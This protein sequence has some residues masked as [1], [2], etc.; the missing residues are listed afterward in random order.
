MKVLFCTDGSQ[1]SYD[2]IT[3]FS[4]WFKNFKTDILS[5]ADWSCLSDTIITEG[6]NIMSYCTNNANAIIN[7]ARL[8]LEERNIYVRNTDKNCGS[9]T[10]SILEAE[11]KERYD[12]LVLGSNGKKGIQRWL[13]SVSQDIS[14]LSQTSVY[15]S[16]RKTQQNKIAFALEESLIN[17]GILENT[18]EYM[19]LEDKEIHLL[20]VYETPD[21]MFLDGAIDSNWI[22][23]ITAK[24][25]KEADKTLYK[26]E[27]IFKDYGFSPNVK[28]I[29]SGN[30]SKEIIEYCSKNEI[31]LIVSGMRKRKLLSRMFPN[32]V[33]K[34]ILENTESDILIMK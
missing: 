12:F 8:Y 23:D 16:K 24:Q 5:V 4:K 7:N 29:L 1:I 14:M 17:R 15:I 11:N 31:D 26:F 34:R 22:N 25:E 3:N 6:S 33:S 18:L 28:S 2:S 32:S 20:T 13:G 27:G 19:N 21:Y 10:D 9:V 30:P